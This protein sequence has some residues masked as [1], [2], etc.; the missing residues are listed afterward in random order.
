MVLTDAA[1]TRANILNAMQRMFLAA[2]E[3][4]LVFIYVSSHG[5]PSSSEQG[6]SGIGYIV[7]YDTARDHIWLDALE[8][9]AFARQAS[10]LK[11]RRKIVFLDT[12]YSGQ[13]RLEDKG[14]KALFIDGTG[15]AAAT[16]N[17]FL[18]G[19][20]SYVVTASRSGERSFES[21]TLQNSYFTYHLMAALKR[22]GEPPTLRQ[23]FDSVAR[24]V[25]AAVARDKGQSQHPQLAPADGI[26]DLRIGVQPSRP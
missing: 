14:E 13:M 9:Q 19:E 26:A 2:E 20:G 3:D 15:V 18:S 8:Y 23:V 24:D 5:S 21:D 4:D 12:C 7:T 22:A 17:L 16:A 11:A 6:L 25:P 10:S 1:A